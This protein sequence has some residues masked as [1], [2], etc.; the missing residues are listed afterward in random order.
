MTAEVQIC[1]GFTSTQWVALCGR[2]NQGDEAAWQC[3]VEVFQRRIRERFFHC[4]E[5]LIEGDSEADEPSDSEAPPDCSA[6]PS[7]GQKPVVVPGFSILALCCLLAETLQRF[8]G[9]VLT[10]TP[11]AGPC[12]FPQEKCI[13][14]RSLTRP[15]REL[16]R[17]PSFHGA[18]DDDEVADS[19]VGDVRN[20]LLHEAETRR[21][22]IWRNEPIGMIV[23]KEG[24]RHA[25]NRTE[26]YGALKAEF[27]GYL[28]EL[29][30]PSNSSLRSH[31]VK[32]MNH[33]A[34]TA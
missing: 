15:I 31:F 30:D 29:R 11:A 13:R 7:D 27:A 8:R 32:Q 33:I 19:F 2:L 26:F 10:K 25:L 6:L 23:G 4:I 3:A 9:P 1:R 24:D 16:L 22:V 21:W 14:P 28:S 17:R 12:L 20:G 34:E 5:V 18:F